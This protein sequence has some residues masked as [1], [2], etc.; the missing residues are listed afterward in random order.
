MTDQA[1]PP[2]LPFILNS[3]LSI[4]GR[5]KRRYAAGEYVPEQ[6]DNPF[7]VTSLDEPVIELEDGNMFLDRRSAY[8][9]LAPVE[10]EVLQRM[11]AELRTLVTGAA[12]V[13]AQQGVLP[14]QALEIISVVLLAQLRALRVDPG[15][16]VG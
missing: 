9:E 3:T 6:G 15:V 10:A 5:I 4:A 16:A 12:V 2:P 11:G 7:P 13:L 1:P 14:G 8:R